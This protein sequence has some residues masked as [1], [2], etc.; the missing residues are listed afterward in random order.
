MIISLHIKT[1]DWDIAFILVR[2]SYWEQWK[3][4]LTRPVHQPELFDPARLNLGLIFRPIQ[5]VL[6]ILAGFSLDFLKSGVPDQNNSLWHE[7]ISCET[8][9][10]AI[11][12]TKMS[13][14]GKLQHAQHALARVVLQQRS[15]ARSTP[16]MEQLH[17]LP[18]EWRI[19]FKLATL[20][21]KARHTGRPPYLADLIQHHTTPKSTRSSSSQLY[22]SFHV[23]TYH[24]VHGLSTSLPLTFGI[25]AS[26]H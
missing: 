1:S 10:A 16:L 6:L 11:Y 12:S 22:F 23:I 2:V 25:P 13:L 21:Y 9:L 26:S 18:I 19:R 8:G 3:M 15:R 20:T 5:S 7:L 17:W 24:L 4:T 14:L